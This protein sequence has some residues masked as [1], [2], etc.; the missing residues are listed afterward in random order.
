MGHWGT[1]SPGIQIQ[2]KRGS[3]AVQGFHKRRKGKK[4]IMKKLPRLF[5][6]FCIAFAACSF[7]YGDTKPENDKPDIIM[8]DVEYVRVRG[9]EPLIRFQAEYAE[10]YE[11]RNVMNLE[12]FH[13]EEFNN[14]GAEVNATGK[15]GEASI[16]LG[17]G[18]IQL[19]GGV[20]IA[21]ESEDITIETSSLQWKDREKE[22]SGLPDDE[23]EIRRSDGTG[24]TGRGFSANARDRTWE[25]SAGAEG[26]YFDAD[27]TGE[28]ENDESEDV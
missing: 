24:F 16:E 1:I 3:S 18:N 20:W 13:F 10:R 12:N 27:E 6:I 19:S 4:Q 25:F 9:G 14:G 15:A 2:T 28:T 8:H 22:L 7:D 17:P 23:V 11:E 21:I 5:L 26:S